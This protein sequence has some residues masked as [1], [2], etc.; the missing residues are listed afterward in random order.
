MEVETPEHVSVTFPLADLG[1][2]FTTLLIDTVI[3]TGSLLVLWVGIPFLVLRIGGSVPA[4]LAGWGFGAMVLI[5]FVVQSGYF[6][7]F[8]GLRGGQTPGKR[9]MGI[10]VVHDGGYPLTLQGATIRNLIRLIDC[11]PGVSWLVGG[12]T[13]MLHPATKRLG[14]M[15]AGTLVVRE[16]TAVTLPEQLAVGAAGGPPRLDAGE[17]AALEQY[18]QR[19]GALAPDL[20]SRI[21]GKLAVRFERYAA[22]QRGRQRADDFLSALHETEQLRRASSGSESANARA[23]ALVRH[24]GA[25][26]KEFQALL[27]RATAGGLSSLGEQEV[28]RFAALYREVAADLARARTYGGSPELISSLQRLTGS[29]HN[30]LYRPHQWSWAGFRAWLS[31]GFPTLVRRQWRPIAL[32]AAL[33]YLPAILAFTATRMDPSLSRT[34][35]PAE[36]LSRAERGAERVADGIGYY[37]VPD[38]QMPIMASQLIA[39]NVQ[40]S[41]TAFAGGMLGGL[42]T[43][44]VLVFNGIFLGAVAGAFANHG[45]SLYLWTFVLP[46]GVIE[47]TAIAIAGGAGLLLGSAILLPGRMTRREALTRRGRDAVSL[48][49]GTTVLL[50]IAGIIEGFISPSTIPTAAKL[51]FAALF[52]VVLALYLVGAGRGR[53]GAGDRHSASGEAPPAGAPLP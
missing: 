18:I 37:E 39:N 28:S 50:L 9:W 44:A 5:A 49:A 32:S 34:V 20:R 33:L 51:S 23:V 1:S 42:G 35:L 52:A 46:H 8:E 6:V 36:M 14:D 13:M 15:A 17:F 30:L 11:Q 22:W 16:E 48:I 29:G 4:A 2:R 47:L 24:Q 45:L 19:R 7:L 53:R 25:I 27:D 3:G 21:A 10:R 12:A 40:V 31:V 26:W 43:V 41:F 38:V